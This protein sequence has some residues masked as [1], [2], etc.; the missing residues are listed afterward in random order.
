MY[1]KRSFQPQPVPARFAWVATLM[2]GLCQFPLSSPLRESISQAWMNKSSG[3][4]TENRTPVQ[5]MKI[6]CPRPLD[7]GTIKAGFYLNLLGSC[8]F[9][10]HNRPRGIS[11]TL[12]GGP[13]ALC[14][15]LFTR[16]DC[17]CQCLNFL[18]PRLPLIMAEISSALQVMLYPSRSKVRLHLTGQIVWQRK[19]QIFYAIR[20]QHFNEENYQTPEYFIV[21]YSTSTT[22]TLTMLPLPKPT[23]FAVDFPT[24]ARSV[25]FGIVFRGIYY[26]L[27]PNGDACGS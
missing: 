5:R 12:L 19:S 20:D 3:D 21:C 1:P 22:P 26:Y 17:S 10:R 23:D 16:Q 24:V 15:A 13:G 18:F 6:S 4:S 7:D 27:K 11:P 8:A 2:V 25:A 14:T 9:N